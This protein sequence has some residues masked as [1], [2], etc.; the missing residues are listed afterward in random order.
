MK[1]DIRNIKET[2]ALIKRYNSITLDEIKDINDA[3][4]LE[5]RKSKSRS[6]Y[7]SNFKIKAEILTGF[8]RSDTCPLCISVMH[9]CMQ[10]IHHIAPRRK[11]DYDNAPSCLLDNSFH[12]I[13]EAKSNKDLLKAFKARAIYLQTLVDKY[14]ELKNK[15]DIK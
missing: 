9:D 6:R 2:K 14:E 3:K 7:T 10:C 1:Y 12:M 4:L 11:T 5:F 15:G 8:G 13:D